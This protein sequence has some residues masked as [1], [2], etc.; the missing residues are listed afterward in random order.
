MMDRAELVELIGEMI[1]W[2]DHLDELNPP[3]EHYP[4]LNELWERFELEE[5]GS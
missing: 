3:D 2:L 1:T 5:E 4:R